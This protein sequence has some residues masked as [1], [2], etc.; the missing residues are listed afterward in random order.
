MRQVAARITPF[1]VLLVVALPGMADSRLTIE[2]G[3]GL[4]G[5][6]AELPEGMRESLAN[7]EPTTV[8]YWFT[9][10]RAARVDKSGS[11]IS[12]LDRR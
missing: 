1:V 8:T 7:Q 12:R 4:V 5:D 9:G 10:D 3:S 6:G 11:I 2:E